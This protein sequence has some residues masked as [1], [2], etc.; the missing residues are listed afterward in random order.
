MYVFINHMSFSYVY[1]SSSN[2]ATFPEQC[3]ALS[4]LQ[5]NVGNKFKCCL[6]AH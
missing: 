6:T 5:R 1:F 2:K 3:L 4:V